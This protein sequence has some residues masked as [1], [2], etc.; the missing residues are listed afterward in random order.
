MSDAARRR[1]LVRQYKERKPEVG[2][3]AVRCAASGE[4]WVAASRTL[5]SAR[6][7]IWM[8]LRH[9]SHRNRAMQDAWK[10]HGGDSFTF[11]G[12]LNSTASTTTIASTINTSNDAVALGVTTVSGNSSILTTGGNITLGATNS[13]SAGTN[14]LT[15]TSGAGTID[16]TGAIGGSAALHTLTASSTPAL[17]IDNNITTANAVNLTSSGTI[18]ESGGALIDTATLTTVSVGGTTLAV[19]IMWI[20]ST[21]PTPLAVTSA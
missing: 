4:A 19:Q 10:A 14:T 1:D 11:N 15:L 8:S 16:F 6:N 2:V 5:A 9:G 3:F 18:I 20:A 17:A 7:P 12:G 13:N 21:L